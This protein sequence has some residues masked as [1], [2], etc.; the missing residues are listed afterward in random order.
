MKINVIYKVSGYLS[1]IIGI[2]AASCIY[3]IQLMFYGIALALLGFIIGGINVFLNSKYF[4]E[5]EKYPK[6]Y[7]GIFLS[8][9]PVIFMLLIIFKFRPN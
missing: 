3:K 1:I 2:A 8:S 7:I 4:Y 6:G 9:L 5:Q